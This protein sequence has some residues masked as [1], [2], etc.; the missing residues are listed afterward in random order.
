MFKHWKIR[1]TQG[2]NFMRVFRLGLAIL[3]LMEAWK[4]SQ[5]LFAGLG[6][7]LL[8]QA[9]INVGCCG[10]SGCD[11]NHKDKGDRSSSVIAE[12]TTFEEIK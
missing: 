2:W 1:L 3:V 11:I 9:L 8:F 6:G 5:I 12:E 10:S 4:S 7:I